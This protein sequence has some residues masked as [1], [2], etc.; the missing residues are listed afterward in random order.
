MNQVVNPNQLSPGQRDQIQKAM[1]VFMESMCA[2]TPILGPQ[3]LSGGIIRIQTMSGL[4]MK[5]GFGPRAGGLILP[6]GIAPKGQNGRF[7][8]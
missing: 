6:G 7:I 3:L 4:D 1:N 8:K 2:C 5:L